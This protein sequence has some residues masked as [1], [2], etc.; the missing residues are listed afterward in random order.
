M[1][2]IVLQT[3][4][5]RHYCPSVSVSGLPNRR[6]LCSLPSFF[7]ANP[8]WRLLLWIPAFGSCSQ[9]SLACHTSLCP[10]PRRA[11]EWAVVLIVLICVRSS[12]STGSLF[13][14]TFPSQILPR[15]YSN[16]C[17]KRRKERRKKNM[18]CTRIFS[19]FLLLV[20]TTTTG[21]ATPS[22]CSLP[23]VCLCLFSCAQK[24]KE[25]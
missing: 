22:C 11:N 18:Q 13:H 17:K 16:K 24:E 15:G 21:T 12:S 2:D 20:L 7:S 25:T 5:R 19:S 23:R 14:S 8:S 9:R 3:C 10:Q 6:S 1:I 4:V